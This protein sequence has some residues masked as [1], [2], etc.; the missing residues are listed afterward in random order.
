RQFS[1]R[2][3][4]VD[5][6]VERVAEGA[7]RLPDLLAAAAEALP[8]ADQCLDVVLLHEALEHVEDD[9]QVVHEAYRV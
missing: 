5:I 6:E 3:Y 1:D 4:G 7:T 9:R 8:F 2:V